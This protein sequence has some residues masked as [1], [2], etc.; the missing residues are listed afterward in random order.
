M[1]EDPGK[2]AIRAYSEALKAAWQPLLRAGARQKQLADAT[3]YSPAVVSR[4]F[5]GERLARK[6]FVE[7]LQRFAALKGS[8]L[9]D[10]VLED[11]RRLADEAHRLGPVEARLRH[12]HE[13]IARL[14][15]DLAEKERI[16]QGSQDAAVQEA[17]EWVRQHT[18]QELEVQERRLQELAGELREERQQAR[19]MER[20]RD[21]LQEKV[22]DQ[23][24]RLRDASDLVRE[25]NTDIDRQQEEIRLLRQ[26]IKVL[27]G[28]V[29]RLTEE[30]CVSGVSTQVNAKAATTT[31]TSTKQEGLSDRRS[32]PPTADG[33]EQ[34]PHRST[35][36]K[37]PPPQ[38]API[39]APQRPAPFLL[40]LLPWNFAPGMAAF[41]ALMIIFV[42]VFVFLNGAAF[43][44]ACASEDGPRWWGLALLAVTDSVFTLIGSAILIVLIRLAFEAVPEYEDRLTLLVIVAV[45]ITLAA[46]LLDVGFVVR[47]VTFAPGLWW[48]HTFGISA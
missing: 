24:R 26:E 7:D 38:T 34:L 36:T 10:S 21:R 46:V 31:Q 43:A 14:R 45:L 25:M 2:A 11:L 23:E 9:T 20:E 32:K 47:G 35:P 22:H 16:A 4:Y 41:T 28:Q 37:S 1:S 13:V 30:K 18:S 17:I 6:E 40:P 29:A 5:S 27:R 19:V 3:G 48:L 33:A 12:A 15:A 39:R 44:A 8:P 42:P